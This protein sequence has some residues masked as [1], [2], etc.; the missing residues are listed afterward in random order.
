[1]KTI[2]R[3]K[4]SEVII[5]IAFLIIGLV[6][7]FESK[8]ITKFDFGIINLS[9][10][11]PRI[12]SVL[13]IINSIIIIF[14]NIRKQLKHSS[15]IKSEKQ[16]EKKQV[17]NKDKNNYLPL[18][19]MILMV[20]YI[21]TIRILGYFETGFLFLWISIFLFGDRSRQWLIKSLIIS[22][23]FSFIIYIVFGYMLKIYVPRGIIFSI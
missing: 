4:S 7:Y 9:D 17:E 10:T 13:L 14:N 8:N 3:I 20:A 1:M 18:I 11:Y 15:S 5:S 23:I 22:I 21:F 19:L 12:I 2:S 6:F 16:F